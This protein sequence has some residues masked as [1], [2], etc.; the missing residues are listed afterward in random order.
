MEPRFDD[1]TLMRCA[2]GTAAAGELRALEAAMRQDASLAARVAMFRR[3]AEL[4][5][6]AMNEVLHEPVPRRLIDAVMT[7]PARTE[8]ALDD[9]T[10][11]AYADGALD[12]ASAARVAAAALAR[13]E[14]RRRISAFRTTA[15]LARAAYASVVDEEVPARLVAAV[16]TAPA[17]GNVVALRAKPATAAAAPARSRPIAWAVAASV[18][19]VMALGAGGVFTGS[20]EPRIGGLELASTDRWLENVAGF[21]NL[22]EA[23][24]ASEGRLL[25]DFTAE[26][27]PELGKWFGAKLNRNLAIP[28]L[29]QHGFALQGGRMIIVGGKPAAQL[30]YR[31]DANDTVGLVIAFSERR[32]QEPRVDSRQGVNVVHWHRG[33][34]AYAF[35]GRIEGQRLR[36]LAD[37]AWTDLEAI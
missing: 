36:A 8:P 5:R 2:D 12:A 25:V 6:A 3:T 33:G 15:T 17:A 27:M 11:M 22:A 4:A 1:E 16:R 20:I 10:L 24:Q 7:A 28:D 26:D 18:A 14:I 23:T 31:N 29:T 9:E 32:E 34:Y 37:R 19:L 21:Y 13:P 35:A 30:L